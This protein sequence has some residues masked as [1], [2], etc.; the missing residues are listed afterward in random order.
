MLPLNCKKIIDMKHRLFHIL[1]NIS[2]HGP[3]DQSCLDSDYLTLHIFLGKTLLFPECVN[4]FHYFGMSHRCLNLIIYGLEDDP[5]REIY[6][7]LSDFLYD[8]N[9]DTEAFYIDHA[10][11]MG[12]TQNQRYGRR[13]PTG[14]F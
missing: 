6:D 4:A 14:D 12:S 9:L 10:N 7:L 11:R 2:D 3:W 5:K 1:Q 13:H 8:M